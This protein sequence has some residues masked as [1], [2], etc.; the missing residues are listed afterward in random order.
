MSE[1]IKVQID[2]LNKQLENEMDPTTFVLN[3]A[4]S[5]IFKKIEGLQNQCKHS[6]VNG[7]CEF[8]GRREP[9]V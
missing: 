4:A 6:F 5:M 7:E 1:E 3:P 9:N 2:K 8:C